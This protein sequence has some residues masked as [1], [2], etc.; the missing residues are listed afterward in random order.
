MR[1]KGVERSL[2][3]TAGLGHLVFLSSG[4]W[5]GEDHVCLRLQVVVLQ[6]C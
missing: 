6:A 1:A 4:M 2:E 5:E 3:H